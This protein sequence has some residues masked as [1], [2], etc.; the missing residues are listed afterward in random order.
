MPTVAEQLR[1]AR[2]ARHLSVTQ[3][4]EITKL[5]G[6]HIRALENGDY[7]VFAAPV[8]VRGF[9]RTYGQLLK[10]DVPALLRAA[11]EELQRAGRFAETSFNRLPPKTPLDHVLLLLSRLPWRW[12][13]PVMVVGL[14]AGLSVFLYRGC[15]EEQARDPLSGIPP[16]RH[17]PRDTG[18]TLPL[19]SVPA[20]PARP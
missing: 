5:K 19:P 4:A 11:D 1:A 14:L 8:Y 18:E 2:E 17:Q 20:A 15:R 10:L 13:L 9:L 3:V 12:I 16:A 7:S 6:D